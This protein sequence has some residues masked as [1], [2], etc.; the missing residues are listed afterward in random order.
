MKDPE[1][2]GILSSAA[3]TVG[4][5]AGKAAIALGLE[6][7]ETVKPVKAPKKATA[8]ANR[9]KRVSARSNRVARAASAK[10]TAVALGKGFAAGDLRYRRIVGKTS[11]AWSQADVDYVERLTSDK[12]QRAPA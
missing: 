1:P 12:K 3:R 8:K 11:A 7:A 9:G 2:E 6:D 5:A 10:K 4:H